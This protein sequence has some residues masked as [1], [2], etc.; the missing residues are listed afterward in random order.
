MQ[1]SEA[2]IYYS[3]NGAGATE[4]PYAKNESQTQSSHSS[5]IHSK[6]IIDVNIKHKTIKVSQDNIGEYLSDGGYDIDFQI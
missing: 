1:Y 6:R 5:N 3:T 2:K 4:Y